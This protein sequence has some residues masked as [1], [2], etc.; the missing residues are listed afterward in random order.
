MLSF[1][2]L[3]IN[4]ILVYIAY[5]AFSNFDIKKQFHNKQLEIVSELTTS[6]SNVELSIMFYEAFLYKTGD[7]QYSAAGYTLSFYEIVFGLSY[8]S[9]EMIYVKSNNIEEVFSFLKFRNHPLLPKKI[10]LALNKLYRPLQYS[11]SVDKNDFPKKYFTLTQPNKIEEDNSSIYT[12]KYKTPTDFIRDCKNLR[13]AII[14]WY[15]VY[16]A[17]DLNI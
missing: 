16:G 10:S 5:K 9:F 15:K 1:W 17:N 14:D 2:S 13:E 11:P 3:L 6:I 8:N 7:K 12:Y 4:I